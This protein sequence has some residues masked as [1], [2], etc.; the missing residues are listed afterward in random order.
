[1]EATT[2]TTTGSVIERF[3][4]KALVE[5]S[6]LLEEGAAEAKD[7]DLG[8]MAGAGIQPGPLAKADEMGLDTVLE[9]LEGA[10]SEW[11]D[12]FEPPALLKRLVNQ[13][14]LGRKSGQGFFPY[15]QPDSDF[16]QKETV[17]FQREGST[18]ILWLN[19]PPANPLSP[20]VLN[21]LNEVWKHCESSSD[22]R[23]LIIT[24]SN[25]FTFSAG[26]DIKAFTKMDP[27]EGR[28][29]L[30]MGHSML[31]EWET[32][33]KITIAAVNSLAFGGG[34]EISMGCD[35]RIAAKSATFGQPEINLGIIPGLGGTQRLPRLGGEARALQ[36]NLTG[37]AISAEQ[38]YEY[39]LANEV[40][41]DHELFDTALAWARDLSSKAP[42]A[43]EQIKKVS[44]NA[45]LDEGIKAEMQGFATV[46]G[47]EDAKEGITAFLQ[48]R[49]PKF[50][51]S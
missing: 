43:V 32:S 46:F 7:I 45:D 21:D 27:E 16:D 36:M 17:L 6:L 41:R 12:N 14:R 18:A 28:K 42:I 11:G 44:N 8:M 35:F 19:R 34:C 9:A 24:S 25:P 47:S 23:A 48:K 20:E 38:A 40:V 1:M 37:D 2:A 31:R 15:P 33:S 50:K 39:G 13:N 49:N 26:A 10:K 4:L 51:G 29:M 30:E 22:I 3:T 5:A